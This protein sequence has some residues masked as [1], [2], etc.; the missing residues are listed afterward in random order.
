M[1]PGATLSQRVQVTRTV[2]TDERYTNVEGAVGEPVKLSVI[3]PCFNAA[4]VIA[5]QLEALASQHWSEPWEVIISDNGSTD[6]MLVIVEQYRERLPNLR[7][8]DSSDRRGPGHA[9]NVGALAATGEALAFCDADDEAAPGWVAAMGEALSKYDFVAGRLDSTK[10]NEPWAQKYRL[11]PQQDGLQ[12]Y[13]YPSYLYHAACSNLG[14]KR[15]LHEAVGGFDETMFRLQDTDYCWRIQLAGTKL[16]FVPDALVH[17]RYRNTL[18]GIY[19]QA[20][21]YAEYN[22]LIYKKYRRLGMPQLSWKMGV[23]AWLRLLRKL[24]RIR[25][26]KS[27]AKW[28]WQFGWCMGRLQGSIKYRIFAL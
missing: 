25:S 4:D 11:C 15:S 1:E 9:R 24:W 26:R 3:I 13:D 8:V 6:G 28:V 22:V 12:E 19:R 17:L 7:V 27:L 16:H 18:G 10:L 21:G 2:P 20:R 23:K 5:T 14:V